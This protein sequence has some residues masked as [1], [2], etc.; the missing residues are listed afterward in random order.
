MMLAVCTAAPPPHTHTHKL[1]HTCGALQQGR[2]GSW[3]E[4]AWGKR[5]I[6]WESPEV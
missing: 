6:V 1:P 3:D 5:L 2:Q 4:A